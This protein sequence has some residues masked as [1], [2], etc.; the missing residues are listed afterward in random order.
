MHF[1]A[2]SVNSFHRYALSFTLF[3]K[4][5]INTSS[6]VGQIL[7][8][9]SPTALM[10]LNSLKI[11]QFW[12]EHSEDWM[13]SSSPRFIKHCPWFFHNW[14]SCSEVLH[15]TSALVS[16][17]PV[18]L[19]DTFPTCKGASMPFFFFFLNENWNLLRFLPPPPPSNPSFL[20]VAAYVWKS[21]N[22]KR[23]DTSNRVFHCSY[24]KGL[25]FWL[26]P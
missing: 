2:V 15:T 16:F 4:G 13:K 19:L 23:L 6:F 22:Y 8:S 12:S 5:T 1:S 26:K 10:R 20:Y 9:K 21:L 24:L 3:K 17:T 7:I 25:W 14:Y 18:W 11:P